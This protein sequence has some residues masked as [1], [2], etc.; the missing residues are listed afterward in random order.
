MGT[1]W[2]YRTKRA[3]KNNW[4]LRLCCI[5]TVCLF[6]RWRTTTPAQSVRRPVTRRRPQPPP[7]RSGR[8]GP[9]TPSSSSRRRSG[10]TTMT[11][12]GISRAR[13]YA[14]IFLSSQL[15]RFILH[16]NWNFNSFKAK[17]EALFEGY[18]WH[19]E[20]VYY[21]TEMWTMLIF[22]TFKGTV[23]RDFRTPVFFIIWTSLGFWP[24]G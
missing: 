1:S 24:M 2:T 12:S 13:H 8:P 11:T 17:S 5:V 15:E 22:L 16:F 10:P 21:S 4:T 3:R 18:N 7:S 9:L 14:Q 19:T 20:N 23:Q 6:Y